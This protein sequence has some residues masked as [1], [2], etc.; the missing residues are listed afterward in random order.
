MGEGTWEP[1]SANA[2]RLERPESADKSHFMK[3]DFLW[4]NND[5]I[6]ASCLNIYCK[7]TIQFPAFVRSVSFNLLSIPPALHSKGCSAWAALSE[8]SNRQTRVANMWTIN[9]R[10]EKMQ[11]IIKDT[12]LVNGRHRGFSGQGG[13]QEGGRALGHNQSPV[14]SLPWQAHTCPSQRVCAGPSWPIRVIG[15]YP[16]VRVYVPLFHSELQKPQT[17]FGDSAGW[18]FCLFQQR[19]ELCCP[20]GDWRTKDECDQIHLHGLRAQS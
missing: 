8:E 9:V 13:R 2:C 20:K 15:T 19:L 6:P 1:S 17:C 18:P 12:F 10:L 11:I 4:G 5:Q 14:P 16:R 7:L 3:S